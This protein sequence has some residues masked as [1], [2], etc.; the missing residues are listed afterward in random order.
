MPAKK[1]L[2]IEDNPANMKLASDILTAN[3]YDVMKASEGMAGFEMLKQNSKN[4][5]LVLLDLK[6]PDI[7]GIE[8]IKK[9]KADQNTC[10]IP[11][12]VVSAHAMEAD[13]KNSMEA[14][15]ADYITKPINIQEFLGRI[16]SAV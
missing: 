6:L 12:I 3:G 11:V 8:V 10:N 2:I 15:C 5:N 16:K 1:I 14:G 13:I 9:I 7:D 4:I